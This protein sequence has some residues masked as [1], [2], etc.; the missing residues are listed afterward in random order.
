MK[1]YK[2]CTKNCKWSHNMTDVYN[3]EYKIRFCGYFMEAI[4]KGTVC[5]DYEEKQ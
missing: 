5:E 4:A 3:P 2:E 1:Q